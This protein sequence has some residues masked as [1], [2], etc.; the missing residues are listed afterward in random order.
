VA[1]RTHA[2]ESRSRNDAA[3]A[4]SR[5]LGPKSYE[6][7]V[8]A[9]ATTRGSRDERTVTANGS[10]EILDEILDDS[11]ASGVGGVAPSGDAQNARTA[12][13][14]SHSARDTASVWYRNAHPSSVGTRRG[15]VFCGFTGEDV[16]DPGLPPPNV[17]SSTTSSACL[18][19]ARRATK[20]RP[21]FGSS[22][23]ALHLAEASAEA[24]VWTST[25]ASQSTRSRAETS[26]CDQTAQLKGANA[27]ARPSTPAGP[28]FGGAAPA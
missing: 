14:V 22:H 12:S 7:L 27:T 26:E 28:T 8:S 20:R 5:A 18:T 21:D 9:P 4:C 11:A 6:H 13:A 10:D 17:S 24:R 2:N 23:A 3:L 25:H 16:S 19:H 1:A 15:N